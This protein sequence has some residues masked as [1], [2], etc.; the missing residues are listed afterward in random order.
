MLP[1][2]GSW[3]GHGGVAGTVHGG[4]VAT[5]PTGIGGTGPREAAGTGPLVE[6]WKRCGR[7]RRRRLVRRSELVRAERHLRGADPVMKGL[8]ERYGRCRLDEAQ[9]EVSFDALVR[10][11]VCQQ[12][13]SKA[14]ATIYGRFVEA[15]GGAGPDPES[16]LSTPEERLREAGLSRQKAT[17]LRDLAGRVTDGSVCLGDLHER[18][19]D[20]VI[21]ELTRVKGI[22]PWTAQMFLIFHLGRLD[23]LP[24]GDL[25]VR[26]SARG[27][28]ELE[29]L[30]PAE[31]RELAEPW[32][33]YRSVASWYLWRFRHD[34]GDPLASSTSR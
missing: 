15:I 22:G 12:L 27:A 34:D 5:V 8:V 2:S 14:A 33:P 26:E 7:K 25:A 28:Y 24:V 32:R 11:I 29:T 13:S 31:L 6:S 1:E 17:Y 16:I 18:S 19:D 23:V 30:S 3:N 9:R 21:D 4:I 10:S 20:E